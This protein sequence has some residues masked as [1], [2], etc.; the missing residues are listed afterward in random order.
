MIDYIIISIGFISAL[1]GIFGKSWDEEKKGIKRITIKG[2]VTIFL[3]IASFIF[4]GWSMHSKKEQL[5]FRQERLTNIA[6]RQILNGINYLI[7]DLISQK[8]NEEIFTKLKDTTFLSE[9]GKESLINPDSTGKIMNGITG[10]YIHPFELHSAN[11]KYGENLLND[12]L[13]KYNS[14]LSSELIVKIND[15]INDKY[16]KGTYSLRTQTDYFEL[17]ISETR[18]NYKKNIFPIDSPW[19]YLGLYY[20]NRVY[21]ERR[22]RPGNFSDFLNFIAKLESITKEVNKN[23]DEKLQIF[24]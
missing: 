5:E 16:F 8:S 4:A 2:W 3:T 19:S 13:I 21:E 6:N 20:F 11:I 9:I 1:I 17:A 7:R 18:R 12:A 22:R 24:E 14:T 23:R 10:S 15:V